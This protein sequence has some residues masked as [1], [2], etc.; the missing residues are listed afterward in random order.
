[1]SRGVESEKKGGSRNTAKDLSERKM[2]GRRTKK[3]MQE[4]GSGGVGLD[5]DLRLGKKIKKIVALRYK[6]FKT[7]RIRKKEKDKNFGKKP[8]RVLEKSGSPGG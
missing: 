8:S 3:S 6:P 1:V 4:S 5:G 7:V 2:K